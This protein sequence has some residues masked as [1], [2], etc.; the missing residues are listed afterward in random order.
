M[1]SEKKKMI[2]INLFRKQEADSEA[3]LE[4]ELMVTGRKS[5]EQG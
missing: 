5:Q 3:V 2:P 1:E 4:N